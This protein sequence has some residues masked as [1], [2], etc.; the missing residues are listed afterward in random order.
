LAQLG[1][2]QAE[3][4]QK[5]QPRAQRV[6]IGQLGKARGAGGEYSGVWRQGGVRFGGVEQINRHGGFPESG[7]PAARAGA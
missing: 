2:R 6:A 4:A 1:L 3:L 7:A 5:R